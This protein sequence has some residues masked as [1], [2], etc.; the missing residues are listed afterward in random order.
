MPAEGSPRTGQIAGLAAVGLALCC[1][2]PVLFSA[3]AGVTIAGL[4]LRSWLLG[5]AGVVALVAG[6]WRYRR[7]AR[8]V[9]P[10]GNRPER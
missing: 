6:W 7:R 2:L 10:S 5:L 3:G 9:R 4:A 8:C 1:G